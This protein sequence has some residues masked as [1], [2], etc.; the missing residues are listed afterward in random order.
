[1]VVLYNA[2]PV[3]SPRGP[4][5]PAN[6][7]A[8]QDGLR[9]QRLRDMTILPNLDCIDISHGQRTEGTVDL[10]SVVQLGPLGLKISNGRDRE[11]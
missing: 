11:R 10:I 2:C 9:L 4:K 3:A 6:E 7:L 5:A 1:M 8:W